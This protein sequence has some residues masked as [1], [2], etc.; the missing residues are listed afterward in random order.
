M[1]SKVKYRTNH[2]WYIWSGGDCYIL[3]YSGLEKIHWTYNKPSNETPLSWSKQ[4]EALGGKVD[5]VLAPYNDDVPIYK[6]R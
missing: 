6:P 5:E 1:S 4:Y 3:D 2:S